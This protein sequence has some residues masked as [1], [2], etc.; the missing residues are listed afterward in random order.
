MRKKNPKLMVQIK[1]FIE[2]FY[3]DYSRVPSV[4]D[5]AKNV[6]VAVSS[7]YSYLVEM[8]DK[9]MISY[10]DGII[11]TPKL[12]DLAVAV[13]PAPIVGGIPCG[14]A[15]EREQTI[16]GY[17]PLPVSLFG[18]GKFYVL[19]ADGDSMTGA[20]IDQD[21]LIII[22]EQITADVGDIVVALTNDNQ[23]TWKRVEYDYEK[24]YYLHPE[25]PDYDDIYVDALSIQGVAVK[26]LKN[27]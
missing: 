22:K 19:K 6:G 21:D 16:L 8:A 23:N 18:K 25:N 9:G 2:A 11:S 13:N 15:E 14:P 20:G 10:D 17:I 26:V 12:D 24:G 7:A 5:I 1:E 4:R 3:S 27:L